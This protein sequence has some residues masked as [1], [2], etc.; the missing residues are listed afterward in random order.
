[1][2]R[3]DDPRLTL[4][5]VQSNVTPSPR[6]IPPYIG[7]HGWRQ[8]LL[9]LGFGSYAQELLQGVMRYAYGQR[10]WRVAIQPYHAGSPPGNVGCDGMIA[11]IIEQA[12]V[13][14]YA[15]LGAPVVNVADSH[16][17]RAVPRVGS[18]NLT[19]GSLAA[20]QLLSRG[21]RRFAYVG[22]TDHHFARLRA[23]GFTSRL[24]AAGFESSMLW[25]SGVT[26]IPRADTIAW[27]TALKRPTALLAENDVCALEVMR[28]CEHVGLVVPDDLA[29]LGVDN[30]LAICE[31]WRVPI[32]SVAI[33]A[34]RVGYQA[35]EMLDLMLQGL[36]APTKPLLVPPMAVV[37]RESTDRRVVADALVAKALG[38]L[39]EDQEPALTVDALAARLGKS[40]RQ[41]TR[42]FLATLG[43]TPVQEIQRHRLERAKLL[44]ETT[45][46]RI[47]DVA[48]ACGFSSDT[49]FSTAFR[50]AMGMTPSEYRRRQD[51]SVA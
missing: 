5:R 28:L 47:L 50:S 45:R 32:S 25:L 4:H 48:L 27:L 39:C 42:R 11:Q 13:P 34:H 37:Y 24:R 26:D 23:E 29:V 33:N 36:P 35:A 38:I 21:F 15:G 12:D 20:D 3:L 9:V 30:D 41:L 6:G 16:D 10:S 14:R 17:S 49:S 2:R 46:K 40:R 19:I 43:R 22:F 7:K 8:I 31:N 1:M 18:D 44:L 51:Q